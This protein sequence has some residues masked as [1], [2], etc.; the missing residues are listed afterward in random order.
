MA[1]TF[2]SSALA[3]VDI[4]INASKAVGVAGIISVVANAVIYRNF[5]KTNLH[6]FESPIDE[7]Q[8]VLASFAVDKDGELS[9]LLHVVTRLWSDTVSHI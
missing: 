8:E 4:L 2:G 5:A 6:D 7:S 3:P 1:L 9:F